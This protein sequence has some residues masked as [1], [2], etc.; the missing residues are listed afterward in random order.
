MST[1]AIFL[2]GQDK[3]LE[4]VPYSTYATED[5]LQELIA[6]YPELLAGDQIDPEDPPRWLLVTREAGVPDAAHASDRWSLDHLLL[7]HRA[8]PTLVEVK[9]SSDSR[10]RREVV[11][12]MLEYAANATRYWPMDRIR[13]MAAARSGGADA[14]DERVRRLIDPAVGPDATVDV[15][16]YWQR[17]EENLR[18]GKLRLLFVADELPRE[19]RRLV[20]F[21]NEHMPSIEVLGVE[22]RQ[23]GGNSSLR[24]LVPRVVGQTERALVGRSPAA[25]RVKLTEA[26]FLETTPEWALPLFQD[27]LRDARSAGLSM[28]WATRSLSI[29]GT[30]PSGQPVSLLYAFPRGK[31]GLGMP[32]LEIYLGYVADPALAAELRAMLL[33]TGAFSE[34]GQ[35]TLILP[36]TPE[37]VPLARSAIPAVWEAY[38]RIQAPGP[39]A[40]PAGD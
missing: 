33:T 1:D 22:V 31:S 35:H 37:S 38:R 32:Y 39:S 10:I 5:L 21:L 15:E 12:Q 16:A 30:D 3:K 7:D 14:L 28:T 25:P 40:S 19:L 18:E 2:L 26:V 29:R 13:T 9:R 11:G 4:R 36:L 24:A 17:V 6:E 27:L 23:Y 34:R 8:T 20:E